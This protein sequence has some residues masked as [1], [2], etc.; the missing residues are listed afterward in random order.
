MI[1]FKIMLTAL[2]PALVGLLLVVNGGKYE[3]APVRNA[4]IVIVTFMALGVAIFAAL[5]SIW[6][7]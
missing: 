6:T 7:Y 2:L 5:V 3:D 1:A 4:I